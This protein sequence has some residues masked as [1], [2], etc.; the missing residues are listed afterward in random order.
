MDL[1]MRCLRASFK[2]LAELV[3][4]GA[5]L[6]APRRCNLLPAGAQELDVPSGGAHLQRG[7][8]SVQLAFRRETL[9]PWPVPAL[10]RHPDIAEVRLDLVPVGQIDTG[11]NRHRHVGRDI[12][13]DIARRSLEHRIR[14]F[15]RRGDEL[16]QDAARA[17]FGARR[18][19]P[20]Q[21]DSSSTGFCA[22]Y[23]LGPAQAYA[24]A[25]GLD[26]NRAGDISEF[27]VAAPGRN[28]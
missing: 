1:R 17:S 28:L 27:D 21:L 6:A 7:S 3:V 19:H 8:A 13:D 18:G 9:R 23:P 10:A 12:D 20:V 14:A 15:S 11:A 22:D 26:F 4:R 2:V 5:G 16:R 24:A 25:S